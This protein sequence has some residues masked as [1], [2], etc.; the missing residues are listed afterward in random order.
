MGLVLN[1]LSVILYHSLG[2]DIQA[3][4][5]QAVLL[6]VNTWNEWGTN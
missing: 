5:A 6:E 1:M 3:A 4:L 2:Q